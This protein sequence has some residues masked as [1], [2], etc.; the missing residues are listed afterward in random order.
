[1][2]ELLQDLERNPTV[3]HTG[4]EWQMDNDQ[5]FRFCSRN[6]ELRIERSANGDIIIMAPEGSGSGSGNAELA[7]FF[8]DWARRDGTG[9]IFTSSAGFILP[10]GA[11]RSPDVAWVQNNRLA[12]VPPAQRKKF[13]PICP[14]FVLELRSP[15][16]RLADLKVKM[17]E[18][19]KNGARLGWLLDPAHKQ[20][21]VYRPKATPKIIEN[22]Q[23]MSGAPVLPGF[24]LD[25]PQIWAAIDL[26]PYR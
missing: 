6:K 9:R 15:S 17:Q 22:P 23:R 19:L 21:I 1:M 2:V 18:Y 16:D 12:D 11:M 10:N 5:F 26:E 25:V 3:L 24:T 20:A 13:L 14:D 7:Y 8:V 4:P